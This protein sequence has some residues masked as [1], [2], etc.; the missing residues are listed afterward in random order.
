MSEQSEMI[1]NWLV[2]LFFV[3]YPSNGMILY[4][5][6]NLYSGNLKIAALTNAYKYIQKLEIII[7]YVL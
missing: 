5:L 3:L 6:L 4:I 2:P 1:Q 7:A